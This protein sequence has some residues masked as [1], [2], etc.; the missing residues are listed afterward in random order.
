VTAASGAVA[1]LG[2]AAVG[3]VTAWAWTI[4][5][6]RFKERRPKTLRDVADEEGQDIRA[7][8]RHARCAG[9]RRDMAAA[10]VVPVACWVRG[11]PSCGRGL[12]A[13][14]HV[15]HAGLP[16]AMALTVATFERSGDALPYLWLCAVVAAVAVVDA[17]I[18]LIPWWMP[19][20]GSAVG[21]A[22]MALSARAGG[23]GW[24]GPDG[25]GLAGALGA[26]VG[27]FALFHVVWLLAPG[28]LG[29]GD[30]RLAAMIGLFLGWLDPALALYGL[31]LGSAAGVVVGVASTLA[32]RGGRFA[33][34]PALGL[35]ALLAV[36]LRQALVG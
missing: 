8:L 11:C 14:V 34:G 27:A 29:Y 17:R 12:P 23:A 25:T 1:V 13:T 19:W 21:L 22:L 4:P 35:G 16:V 28:R 10:D 6:H 2:A 32:G 3:L 18:W 36:W 5:L 30:V 24:A 15:L 9:C 26:A 33:F 20:A 31:V 7:V